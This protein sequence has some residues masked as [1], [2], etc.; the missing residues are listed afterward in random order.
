[1]DGDIPSLPDFIQV[2]QRHQAFLMIDEAHSIGTI[3]KGGC[4]I[5]EYFGINPSDVDIW[6]GTLSKSFASCGG[7]VAGNKSLIE[8]LKYTA[9]GFVYSVGMSPP[10]AAAAL[11]AIKLLKSE[12]ERVMRL[13]QRAKLL[14]KLLNESGIDTGN[15]QDSPVIPVI[16]GNSLQ[17][18]QLSQ[19]LFHR[20]I[21]V[22]PIIYPAVP[23]NSSR[24][25][26]FISSTHTEEE[27]YFT[28]NAVIEE[29]K[30]IS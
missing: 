27:I 11:A 5:G 23:E 3:G 25:R 18:L 1:M 30:G 8:Y 9:P 21:N 22:Q 24:L 16:L 29:L 20:G 26:F 4:G 7:Y 10:N 2:K 13:Q 17:C 19:L 28:A 14:L 15:S 12:P 6:M